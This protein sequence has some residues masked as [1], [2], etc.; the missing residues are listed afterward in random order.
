MPLDTDYIEEICLDIK[1]Q[2]DRKIADCALFSMS[3]VP[4]GNPPVD[5]VGIMCQKFEIILSTN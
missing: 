5:K 3:L 2:Y 4:E 1:N